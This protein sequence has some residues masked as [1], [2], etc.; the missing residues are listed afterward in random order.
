MNRRDVICAAPMLGAASLLPRATHAEA[1]WP[2]RPIRWVVGY[3]PGG[4][5][6]RFARL[7]G[8]AMAEELGHPMMV[9]NRPG[10]GAIVATKAVLQAPADGHTLLMADNGMLVSNPALY[11][12][13]P[14]DPDRDL[15]RLGLIGRFAL[16]LIVRRDSPFVGFADLAAAG[17]PRNSPVARRASPRRTTSP[18]SS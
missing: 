11:R 17:G 3:P 2:S 13:L 7:I 9:E 12:H 6:D 16:F 18:W 1:H 15:V 5:M 8:A 10:A 14:F 4:P